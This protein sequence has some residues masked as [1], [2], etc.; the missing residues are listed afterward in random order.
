MESTNAF[1]SEE[2]YSNAFVSNRPTRRRPI[3]SNQAKYIASLK[4]SN[5]I[6]IQEQK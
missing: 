5:H 2:K 6:P 1:V 4:T 3:A